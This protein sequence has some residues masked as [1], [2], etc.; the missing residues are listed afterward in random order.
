MC[1]VRKPYIRRVE[2]KARYSCPTGT[3]FFHGSGSG[4]AGGPGGPTQSTRK[5]S[6][7]AAPREAGG[8]EEGSRTVSWRTGSRRP[9]LS[10][11]QRRTQGP[12]ARRPGEDAGG[13]RAFPGRPRSRDAPF[14][15][16]PRSQ[17]TTF[18]GH[19]RSRDAPFPGRAASGALGEDLHGAHASR[20]PD[21]C[22]LRDPGAVQPASW[23]FPLPSALGYPSLLR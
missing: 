20:R 18:P 23:R 1:A 19:K 15:R 3:V 21:D 7:H 8:S 16:R 2:G 10:R 22:G 12:G 11:P 14:P 5:T 13:T 4:R 17:D 9:F 6:V